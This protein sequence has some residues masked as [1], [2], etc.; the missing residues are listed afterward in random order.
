MILN[1]VYAMYT[2]GK[3]FSVPRQI[4]LNQV[5][6]FLFDFLKFVFSGI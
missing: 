1:I 2:Q 5:N 4:S 3:L 6:Q